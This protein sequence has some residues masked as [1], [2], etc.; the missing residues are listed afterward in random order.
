MTRSTDFS[1]TL[2]FGRNDGGGGDS[3]SGM[4]REG[5]EVTKGI[6]AVTRTESK[7]E[8]RHNPTTQ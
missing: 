4:D 2:R 3:L 6:V 1:T 5:V 8:G 7:R